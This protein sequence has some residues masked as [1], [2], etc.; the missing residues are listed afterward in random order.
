MLVLAHRGLPSVHCP[1]NSA[2][3]VAAAFDSGA[4]GVEIDLRLTFD[5]VLAVSHDLDLTRLTGS[6]AVVSTS[7]WEELQDVAAASG[8]TLA[9][10]E[11][12]LVIASG[13][14]VVLEVKAPPPGPAAAARTSLALLAQL[15]SLHG[16]G[17][18]MDVTVSSFSPQ[19]A[20]S[21][22]RLLPLTGLAVRTALLG[23]PFDRPHALLRQALA[24][25][26]DEIHPHVL[27]LLAEPEAVSR[28]HAL[29]VAVVPWTVNR[30]RALR[31]CVRLGA[32][33]VITDCPAVARSAIVA[34]R[35][36]A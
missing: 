5:G 19:V 16:Q 8:V 18:P 14:R 35:A 27:S 34:T 23:T 29:G 9:R 6:P 24:A 31:R 2:A 33:A 17:L 22:R 13:R 28:A 3:A 1:E 26:H 15:I 20:L 10:F 7:R 12:V 30:H 4:D 25:G 21:V 11:D 32:D 36:A